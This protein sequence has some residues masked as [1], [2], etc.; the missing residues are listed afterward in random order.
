MALCVLREGGASVNKAYWAYT[1]K[2]TTS[3]Y[4]L[5]PGSRR[6][7]ECM[8]LRKC[9]LFVPNLLRPPLSHEATGFL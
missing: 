4:Y 6:D 5:A 3:G 8:G 9:L 7:H 2:S 1:E